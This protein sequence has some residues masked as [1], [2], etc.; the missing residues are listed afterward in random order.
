MAETLDQLVKEGVTTVRLSYPDLHGIARG[1]E[2]PASF[3]DHLLEDGAGYCEA[4]MT[5]DLRHNVV[6]GFEHGFQDIIARPDPATLRRVPWDPEVAVCLAD[7]E[8]MDGSPY[9]VDS[10]GVLKRAIAGFAERGLVPILGPELEFYLCEPDAAAPNGYRRYVDNDSH[11]YTVG[12]VADPA[13]HPA[14]DAA[15]IRRHAAGR[16]RRQPRVRA[17]PVRDQPASFRRARRRR[18]GLPVQGRRQGDGGDRRPSGDV[19]RQAVERRRGVGV[20]SA[21]LIGGR[22]GEPIC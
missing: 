18:P 21:H 12:A 13:R 4:I 17:R 9:G 8:R 10:R 2:F 3:F 16:L 7:L 22:I 11:V 5:V 19:R 6:S 1:K 15:C 14:Q 20:P